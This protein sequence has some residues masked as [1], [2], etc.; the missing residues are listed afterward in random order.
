MTDWRDR[1]ACK[2]MDPELFDLDTREELNDPNSPAR[3]A[4][5][6]CPVSTECLDAAL[7]AEGQASAHGRACIVAGTT[8]RQRARM[9]GITPEP[10]ARIRRLP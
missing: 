2:D 10:R 7:A 3:L 6:R 4:C 9:A 8:P 1:A 5:S